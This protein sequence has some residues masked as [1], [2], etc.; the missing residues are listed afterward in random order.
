MASQLLRH[1]RMLEGAIT[2]GNFDRF[3]EII[4]DEIDDVIGLLLYQDQIETPADGSSGLTISGDGSDRLVIYKEPDPTV[5]FVING[6]TRWEHGSW[7]IDGFYLVKRGGLHQGIAS[8]GLMRVD[9]AT[10]RLNPSIRILRVNL[11]QLG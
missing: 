7:V 2:L 1:V 10:V 11:A 8:L 5:E 4:I 3:S 6:G 9:E